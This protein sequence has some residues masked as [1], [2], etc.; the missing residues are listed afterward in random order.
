[1]RRVSLWLT[2]L[3]PVLAAAACGAGGG[4]PTVTA[5]H[6][7]RTYLDNAGWTIHV[8]PGWHAVRFSDSKGG[9]R[10]AGIQLSNVRLPAPTLLPGY[11]IQVNG[12][13]LPP[14]G[15]GLIIATDTDRRLPHGNVAEPPLPLPWP[16]GS[17]GGWLIGSAP[18]RSPILETLWFRVSHT[19][20]IAAATIG[21]QAS[22]AD[23]KAL[24]QIIR[25]I[26]PS[27]VAASEPGSQRPLMG[28]G[29]VAGYAAH[30][31]GPPPAALLP[32]TV[33]ARSDGR[34]VASEVVRY[35]K[36]HDRYRLLLRPGR[37]VISARG[38][39]DPPRVVMLHPAE[40]IGVNFQDRCS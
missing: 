23:Q 18:P 39:A 24:G 32:V 6:A 17:H 36:D 34:T 37:Y 1:M 4:S 28:L 2:G 12:E 31:A 30:C 19:T 20:Y 13:V 29:T 14:R 40:H 16:D 33:A 22:G 26:K 15:V 9:V 3:I 25:A 7:G 8:P 27:K 21:W 10:S 11:A 35:L 38:S 5:S